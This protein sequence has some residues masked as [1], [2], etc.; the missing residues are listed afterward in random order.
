M[1][2]VDEEK[3]LRA[4]IRS[5]TTTTM[6]MKTKMLI[7][8]FLLLKGTKH[9]IFLVLPFSFPEVVMNEKGTGKRAEA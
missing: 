6:G 2:S 5:S 4:S 9:G 8:K 3:S 1:L 7:S